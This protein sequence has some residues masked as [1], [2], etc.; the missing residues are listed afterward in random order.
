MTDSAV[1][2]VRD[3]IGP[4]RIH[5]TLLIFHPVYVYSEH[6]FAQGTALLDF[7]ADGER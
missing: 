2:L 4:F 3:R 5:I 1:C 7:V 6:T